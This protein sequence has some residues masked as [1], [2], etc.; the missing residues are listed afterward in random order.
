M[1]YTP[2][3]DLVATNRSE[4][5]L[6]CARRVHEKILCSG[7]ASNTFLLL[8]LLYYYYYDYYSV[9]FLSITLFLSVSIYETIQYLTLISLSLES[10]CYYYYYLVDFFNFFYHVSIYQYPNKCRA[11]VC[12]MLLVTVDLFYLNEEQRIF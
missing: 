6:E 11:A 7:D 10:Y 1:M 9:I 5:R 2:N 4:N 3:S 12:S 8:L